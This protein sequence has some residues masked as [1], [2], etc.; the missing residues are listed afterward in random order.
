MSPRGIAIPGVREQLFQAAER[1]LVREGPAGLSGRAIT[2]EAGVATGVLHKHFTDFDEFLAAF[3]LDR[4]R[5]AVESVAQ[6]LAHPGQGTV[7]RTLTEAALTFGTHVLAIAGLVTSRASLIARLHSTPAT[8]APPEIRQL[9]PI[10]EAFADY[11]EAEKNLGRV[12]ADADTQVLGLALVA[13]VHHLWLT[14]RAGAPHITQWVERV[15]NA[16]LSGSH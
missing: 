9:G 7:T 11:L 1:V 12:A 8:G 13:T 10:E 5:L 14:Q 6:I 4:S 3:V 2:R 15:V 16:L